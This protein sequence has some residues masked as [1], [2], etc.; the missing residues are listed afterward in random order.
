MILKW[1]HLLNRDMR[2]NWWEK[3]ARCINV[4]KNLSWYYKDIFSWYCIYYIIYIYK[5]MYW[6]VSNYSAQHSV[7]GVINNEYYY[8]EFASYI[9][10]YIDY[11]YFII[12][13]YISHSHNNHDSVHWAPIYTYIQLNRVY[14]Y[15]I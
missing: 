13:V 12:G 2:W 6:K 10:R 3:L 7:L 15:K 11:W 14:D 5:G 1:W 8:I 9:G 4:I